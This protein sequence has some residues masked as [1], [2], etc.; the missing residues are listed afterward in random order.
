LVAFFDARPPAFFAA[1]P[2]LRPAARLAIFR[3]AIEESSAW[4][5]GSAVRSR[6]FVETPPVH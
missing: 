2:V 1:V 6:P 5:Q 3:F 4:A